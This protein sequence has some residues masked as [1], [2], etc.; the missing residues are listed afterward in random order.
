MGS[1]LGS[2]QRAVAGIFEDEPDAR[3]TVAE[4]AAR[5]YPGEAVTRS[6]TNNINRVLR[7]LAPTLG[8]ARVRVSAPGRFGWRHVWGRK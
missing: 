5:V 6:H 8:L 1:G 7:Q 2:A 4:V 3:L